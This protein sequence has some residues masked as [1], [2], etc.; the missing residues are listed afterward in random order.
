MWLIMDDYCICG[1]R[2]QPPMP[3]MIGKSAF[4]FLLFITLSN[5]RKLEELDKELESNK[6]TKQSLQSKVCRSILHVWIYAGRLQF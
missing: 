4:A 3:N 2:L 5:F 1:L 6:E